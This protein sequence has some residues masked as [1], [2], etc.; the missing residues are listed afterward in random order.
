MINFVL[1]LSPEW[2]G[3]EY[4]NLKDVT[5]TLHNFN[6]ELISEF[7]WAEVDHDKKY[8]F[9]TILDMFCKFILLSGAKTSRAVCWDSYEFLVKRG[10]IFDEEGVRNG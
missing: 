9:G 3:R 4:A 7:L 6:Y 1:D 5:I 10:I 8:S 2:T